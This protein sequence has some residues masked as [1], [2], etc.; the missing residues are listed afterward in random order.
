MGYTFKIGNAT[1]RHDKDDFPYLSA[2]WDV[3][4]IECADAPDIPNDICGKR[5]ER[6]PRYSVWADFLRATDLYDLLMNERG[7]PVGGHPGCWGLT[8]EMADRISEA[9]RD[10]ESKARLPAGFERFD[11]SGPRSYD[12]TLARLIW[13]DW[14]VRWAVENCE[15]PAIANI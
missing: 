2:S 8:R 3:D 13:L 4:A 14:W 5:N 9:R 12:D 6:S 15:T 10:Y 1:P 11:H 7:S